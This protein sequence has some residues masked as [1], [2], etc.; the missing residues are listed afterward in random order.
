MKIRPLAAALMLTTTGCAS[1]FYLSESDVA[2]YLANLRSDASANDL[3]RSFNGQLVQIQFVPGTPTPQI[4]STNILDVVRANPPLFVL[5][6]FFRQIRL[7]RLSTQVEEQT[8]AWIA[9]RVSELVQQGGGRVRL[10][11]LDRVLVRILSPPALAYDANRQSAAFD[12]TVRV[13]LYGTLD[14]SG[15]LSDGRYVLQVTIDNYRLSGSLQLFPLAAAAARVRVVLNP[16]PGRVSVTGDAPDELKSQLSQFMGQQLSSPVDE[17]RLLSYDNFSVPRLLLTSTPTGPRLDGAYRSRP[18]VADPILDAVGR[19]SEGTLYHVRRQG[20]AW[21]APVVVPLRTPVGGDPALVASGPDQLELVAVTTTGDLIYSGWRNGAWSVPF[22]TMGP[23]A[24][25][26][27]ALLATAPGQ[28][29]IVAVGAD[30]SFHHIRRLNGQWR[31]PIPLTAAAQ[32]ATRPLRHPLLLQVGNKIVLFY[33]DSQSRVLAAVFDLETTI[34]A[35]AVEIPSQRTPFS[36]TAASCEDGRIDLVYVRADATIGLIPLDLEVGNILPNVATTGITWRSETT[37]DGRLAGAPALTCSGYRRMELVGQGLDNRLW[38]NHFSSFGGFAFDRQLQEG[39][40]GWQEAS[41]RFFGTVI[42]GYIGGAIALAAT[43]SGQVHLAVRQGTAP[44]AD[45]CR[46]ELAGQSRAVLYDSYDSTRF[47]SSPWTAVHW[48]G[49]QESG[50]S[51]VG[52]PALA[53]SDR[54]LEM[55]VVGNDGNVWSSSLADDGLAAF[56]GSADTAVRFPFGPVVVSSGSGIVDVIY[57]GADGRPWHSRRLNGVATNNDALDVPA[58]RTF[59]SPPAVVGFG[60]GQLEVVALAQDRMLYHWRRIDGRWQAPRSIGGTVIS[61]PVLVNVGAGQLELLAV[62]IDQRLYH[63]RFV[64]AEWTKASLLPTNFAVSAVFF[65]PTAA[66]TSGDGAVEVMVAQE[67]TAR[68][69]HRHVFPGEALSSGPFTLPGGTPT[70]AEIGGTITD[71]P[72]LTAFSPDRLLV[73]VPGTDGRL[74]T[75]WGEV[76]APQGRS[77][78]VLHRVG[79]PWL[80][81]RGFQ[82]LGGERLIVGGVARLGDEDLAALAISP[83]GRLYFARYNGRWSPFWPLVRQTADVQRAP[84]VPPS[85]AAH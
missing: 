43:R 14:V 44:K 82:A 62:Q 63:W 64:N 47:G 66:G 26:K 75:N 19:G 50:T 55:A 4:A 2:A 49:L 34:W 51:F 35:Q 22:R 8:N 36:P 58:G 30:G 21:S 74:Y 41:E 18:E 79:D 28:L 15:F 5:E 85:I 45:A 59:A 42:P 23:F 46:V 53:I 9:E 48:R 39:W 68:L 37:V 10:E 76:P 1:S 72:V 71:V 52:D 73:V 20:N 40:Q 83:D 24:A 77:G 57:P 78:L 25:V 38:H 84:P 27:P 54:Q 29:E 67:R 65:G 16:Q 31:A 6:Q 56:Q 13:D 12:L 33:G 3:L 80:R 7:D 32:P 69:F 81:W 11:Q 70:F 17:T 61:A 60:G